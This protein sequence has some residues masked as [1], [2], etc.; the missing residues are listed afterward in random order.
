M[1][2]AS[3]AVTEC[4]GDTKQQNNYPVTIQVHAY[5][6]FVKSKDVHHFSYAPSIIQLLQ[7]YKYMGNFLVSAIKDKTPEC[8]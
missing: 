7:F 1:F 4:I 3:W 5:T 6:V 2:F 8:W